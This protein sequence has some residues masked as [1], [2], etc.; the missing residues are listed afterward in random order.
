MSIKIN[1][2]TQL[3]E[4]KQKCSEWLGTEGT[5]SLSEWYDFY[6]YCDIYTY[7]DKNK[8]IGFLVVTLASVYQCDPMSEYFKINKIKANKINHILLFAV[9]PNFRGSG[10]GSALFKHMYKILN[11]QGI[12]HFILA[13]RK[14]NETAKRFYIKQGFV[15]T[16]MILEESFVDP[17]DDQIMMV[18]KI[19][20]ITI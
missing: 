17:I 14:E 19:E 3:N 15:E 2:R 20:P 8:I 11:L 18:K 16:G 7:V 6:K 4:L 13:M 12:T 5:Y 9:D 10:I 1:D